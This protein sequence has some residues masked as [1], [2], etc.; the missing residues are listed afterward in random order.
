MSSDKN[1]RYSRSTILSTLST[2]V[3][4][5][6]R[7]HLMVSRL[8]DARFLVDKQLQSISSTD[9]KRCYDLQKTSVKSDHDTCAPDQ[10]DIHPLQKENSE[11]VHTLTLGPASTRTKLYLRPPTIPAKPRL[12]DQHDMTPREMRLLEKRDGIDRELE[13]CLA[14]LKVVAVKFTRMVE[15]LSEMDH[16]ELSYTYRPTYGASDYWGLFWS[17]FDDNRLL[18]LFYGVLYSMMISTLCFD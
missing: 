15:I 10:K 11:Q 9:S 17:W 8:F 3:R 2:L 4:S 12:Q 6:T 1:N 5:Q 7:L 18:D 16:R 13:L 14:A